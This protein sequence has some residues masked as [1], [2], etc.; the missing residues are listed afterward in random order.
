MGGRR[1]GFWASCRYE[2]R[3]DRGGDCAIANADG[4]VEGVLLLLLDDPVVVRRTRLVVVDGV[5]LLL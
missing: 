1:C 5:L 3:G 4:K 2:A